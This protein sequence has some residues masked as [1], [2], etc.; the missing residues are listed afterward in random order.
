MI[1]DHHGTH[2][3]LSNA[4][5]VL[6][7]SSI[8]SV[9]NLDSFRNEI[10]YLETILVGARHQ[11]DHVTDVH[12]VVHVR[13]VS[14]VCQRMQTSIVFTDTLCLPYSQ[15]TAEPSALVETKVGHDSIFA[16]PHDLPLSAQ[17]S[18]FGFWL[19]T[20]ITRQNPRFVLLLSLLTCRAN[21]WNTSPTRTK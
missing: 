4:V 20:E 5:P 13:H 7:T 9:A 16:N 10:L 12:V 19:M 21:M 11:C 15:N 8:F 6:N 3:C 17:P 18:A 2:S 1:F 14:I